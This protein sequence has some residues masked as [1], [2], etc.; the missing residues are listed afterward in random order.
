MHI[1]LCAKGAEFSADIAHAGGER[2]PGRSQLLAMC[3]MSV[4][5][6]VEPISAFSLRASSSGS[7]RGIS[8]GFGVLLGLFWGFLA[9]L[10]GSF[11]VSW[12]ALRGS[13]GLLGELWGP[14]ASPKVGYKRPGGP[15]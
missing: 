5:F 11:G 4:G 7:F 15:S 9:G 8:G 3:L 13:W 1:G 6:S 14:P 10:L 2:A 12:G